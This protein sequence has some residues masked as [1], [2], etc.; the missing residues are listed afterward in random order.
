MEKPV[1]KNRL[2]QPQIVSA[3]AVLGHLPEFILNCSLF[4]H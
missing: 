2:K 3:P 4:L 1:M